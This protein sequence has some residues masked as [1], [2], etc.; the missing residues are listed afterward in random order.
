LRPGL[1][2]EPLR[3]RARAGGRLISR[4]AGL[5]ALLL[6]GATAQA[7]EPVTIFAAASTTDAVSAV[8][9]AFEAGG[10]GVVRPVYA[11]SSTLAQQIA[12]G[13]PADLFLSANTAWMDEL[14]RRGAIEPETRVDLL[15]NALVLIAPQA[16]RLALEIEPGFALAA[17]LRERRLAMGDPA[18][19]PAG[20]YAKAALERLGVWP[21]VAKRAA[22]LGDV[23]AA[24][25]LVDRRE[26]A[27]GIVYASDARIAPRV[28]VVGTFPADSHPAIVYPLAVVSGRG[29]AA[30]MA[31]YGYLRGAEARA[32]FR[33]Q[34]FSDP[35]GGG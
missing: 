1:S 8:A 28:R 35:A 34:G 32:L 11:A 22:F 30:V 19:V 9:R 25:A 16:S 24:L 20:S 12:R 17:A 13:A 31:L 7:G 14:E 26:A 2:R 4:L 5:A 27:A 29:N 18:H 21:E 3:G 23:R 33:A 15:G 10:G 6:G